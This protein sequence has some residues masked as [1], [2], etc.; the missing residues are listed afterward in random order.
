M[1]GGSEPADSRGDKGKCPENQLRLVLCQ[2]LVQSQEPGE[3]GA[4]IGGNGRETLLA[5]GPPT[6]AGTSLVKPERQPQ[7]PERG[8]PPLPALHWPTRIPAL[9][10][11]LL[12]QM[13]I[14][15]SLFHPPHPPPE[16]AAPNCATEFKEK[17]AR[18][19]RVAVVR[20]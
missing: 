16:P 1:S 14:M 3:L 6:S 9:A 4:A 2:T 7:V 10:P 15:T 5:P 18:K 8:A 17:R 13:P 19:K 20:G 12:L 11:H